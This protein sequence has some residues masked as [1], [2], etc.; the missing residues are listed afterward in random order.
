MK[1]IDNEKKKNN[2]LAAWYSLTT[3]ICTFIVGQILLWLFPDGSSIWASILFIL[4]NL[5]PMI[6]AGMFSIVSKEEKDI[7]HFLKQVFIQWEKAEVWILALFVPVIYY[8]V[9]ILLHN[10]NYTGAGVAA[11]LV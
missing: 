9:S 8:G 6:T 1:T 5:I 11:F 10:V 4:I 7:G 2:T 3:I